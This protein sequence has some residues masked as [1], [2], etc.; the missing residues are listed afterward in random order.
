MLKSIAM[1]AGLLLLMG[2]SRFD[3]AKVREGCQNSHPNDQV[4]ANR[5]LKIATDEWAKAS[6]W[7]PRVINR[8]E[9]TP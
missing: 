7:F 8:R 6:A 3:E 4:A 2:C 1:T 9:E 5:C